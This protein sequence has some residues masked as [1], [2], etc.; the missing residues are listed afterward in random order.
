MTFHHVGVITSDIPGTTS[1]YQQ[2]GYQQTLTVDD[3]IQ[4]AKIVLLQSPDG[5]LIELVSP[6]TEESPAFSWIKKIIAGPYHTCFQCQDLDNQ[7]KVFENQGLMRVS[8]IVTAIA[9]DHRRIIFLWNKK[10]GLIE[11]LEK[12]IA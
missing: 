5:P 8:E 12:K 3:P 2:L 9:F 1:F 7:V 11:L 4:K 6:L 10:T